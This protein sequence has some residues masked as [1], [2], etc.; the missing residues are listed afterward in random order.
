MSDKTSL[1]HRIRTLRE[2]C[3]L[4]VDQLAEKS[5]VNKKLIE[6]LEA[7]ELVASLS[8]MLKI[9]R[10]LGVQISALIDDAPTAAPVVVRGGRSETAME[11]SGL[12]PYCLST[13]D[14]HPLAKNKRN[15][16]MEPF[17]VDVHPSIPEECTLSFHEGEEFLYVL[18]GRIE[19]L[20]GGQRYELI[21]G[22][23]IY[24]DSTTPH[25]VQALGDSD[26]RIVAVIYA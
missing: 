6:E 11:M 15:R 2:A 18:A 5:Q 7:G 4:S 24:Y 16:H 9:A 1:G 10:G 3:K 8:P 17:I 23:S 12:G 22:D 19:V 25:Q 26:A 21:P 14:F 13:L 20:H